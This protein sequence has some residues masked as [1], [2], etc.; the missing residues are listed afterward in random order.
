MEG[1]PFKD[2]SKILNEHYSFEHHAYECRFSKSVKY[3]D[4]SLLDFLPAGIIDKGKTGFGATTFELNSER[5]SIIVEPLKVTASSKA[6]KN[7]LYIGSE[8]PKHPSKISDEDII[9][10]LK[11]E[12]IEFKKIICV[13]DSLK[14]VQ[15]LLKKEFF[16]DFFLMVD[17]SDSMQME[18][19][20]R[21]SM[22]EVFS[23]YK[24]HP[25]EK[26]CLI[27]A[28]PI[29][30]HDPDLSEE[31]RIYFSF[32]EEEKRTIQIIESS[33][34]KGTAADL[35][36]SLYNQSPDEKIVLALNNVTTL[37]EIAY[38]LIKKG[39][40][41]ED[42]SILCGSNSSEKVKG[43]YKELQEEK[44]PTRIVLKTSAYYTGFDL[45]EQYHLIMPVVTNDFL[46]ILSDKRITQIAGRA[47]NGLLSETIIL[48]FSKK[49]NGAIE[50]YTFCQLEKMA[51]M[52]KQVYKCIESN[53][54]ENKI[55]RNRT[56]ESFK[57]M[58]EKTR[59]EGFNL[60]SLHNDTPSISYLSI[61]AILDITK[62]K[63]EI[64]SHEEGLLNALKN[65]GHMVTTKTASSKTKISKINVDE[66]DL[67]MRENLVFEILSGD[68]MDFSIRDHYYDHKDP[69]IRNVSRAYLDLGRYF[70]PDEFKK[71]V[72]GVWENS[73]K[74]NRFIAAAKFAIR[75]EDTPEKILIKS[76]FPIGEKFTK[77]EI[78]GKLKTIQEAKSTGGVKLSE[79][80]EK[81]L[82]D[83]FR[84][85][86]H[87]KRHSNDR[88]KGDNEKYTILGYN[89]I[90]IEPLGQR[91]EPRT[92]F[93]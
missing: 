25:K 48:N 6:G 83:D 13:S 72:L 19:K 1:L 37:K 28:T 81:A 12:S 29:H 11:D 65:S 54:H 64:Y 42:I 31:L 87:A 71:A 53:F 56:K 9:D 40:N 73:K 49:E 5:N 46:N 44:L 36:L 79:S 22:E 35:I 43:F 69:F 4:S 2:T 24:R 32:E 18:S 92:T 38:H 63:K 91:P 17:E 78:I 86:V 45:H 26:R 58:L 50:S 61:D 66:E 75:P 52:N 77:D 84:I 8:T 93:G 57:A 14:R 80:G 15:K 59:I 90:G 21:S 7:H 74:M 47:R 55:L 41:K 67:K 89:T 82:M 10:Y 88:L 68:I 51:L 16:H 30:F 76:L 62:A 33:N 39:V 27:S 85:K 3:L 20:Y 34:H 23:I 60:V 70:K